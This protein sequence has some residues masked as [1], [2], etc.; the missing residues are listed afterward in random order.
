MIYLGWVALGLAL[1]GLALHRRRKETAIWWWILLVF[2]VFSLGPYLHVN[3]EYVRLAGRT[4]PLPFL[5]FFQAFPLFSRISHPFRFVVPPTPGLAILAGDGARLL[6]RGPP[7]GRRV[8]CRGDASPS[9]C[10][11]S[12]RSTR[13]W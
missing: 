10:S 6:P 13:R 3:G 5:P 12:A 7:R 9:S 8:L 4:V 11:F 1:A 2:W